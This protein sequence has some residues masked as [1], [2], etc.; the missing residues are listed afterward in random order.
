[1]S[2]W[3]WSCQGRNQYCSLSLARRWERCGLWAEAPWP[4]P[5]FLKAAWTGRPAWLPR[6]C[7]QPGKSPWCCHMVLS[8]T[9][10]FSLQSAP[11]F[12]MYFI[13]LIS[14]DH[15]RTLHEQSSSP[16][17]KASAEVSPLNRFFFK[18]VRSKADLQCLI[19]TC[20]Q[21][22]TEIHEP[23]LGAESFSFF[24]PLSLS[25]PFA[26]FHSLSLTDIIMLSVITPMVLPWF[27]LVVP[28]IK[29]RGEFITRVYYK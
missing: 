9:W 22:L 1:M 4:L 8:H 13:L 5:G 12:L 21:N 7:H 29:E 16:D 10:V 27:S 15:F 3:K 23:V 17:F 19:T 2:P 24:L 11:L 6:W 28:S 26:L 25:Y 18:L 20:L 14:D